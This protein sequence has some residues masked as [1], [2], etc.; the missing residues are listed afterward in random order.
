MA[1]ENFRSGKIYLQIADGKLVQSF[2]EPREGAKER[3]NK[4]GRQVFEIHHDAIVGRITGIQKKENDY[5]IF[6]TI[7]INDGSDDYQ[8]STQ[9]SGR[10]SSSFLKS[11]PNINLQASVRLFPWSMVDKNDPTKKVTGIT[12][13]Q[14]DGNG[15]VKVAPYYTKDD[16]RGLPQMVKVK[17]KGKETWDDTDMMSHLFESGQK[18]IAKPAPAPEKPLKK[19]EEFVTESLSG[20]DDLPF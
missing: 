10:Y 15:W 18:H 20:G 5:G 12:L 7:D 17:I 8:I 2:K 14:E 1:L 6:L 11:L 4:N 16:P 9:F 13:Y 3:I 19:G